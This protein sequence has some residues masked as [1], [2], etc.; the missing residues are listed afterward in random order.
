MLGLQIRAHAAADRSVEH[1]YVSNVHTTSVRNDCYADMRRRWHKRHC[2]PS[3]ECEAGN[4]SARWH[5]TWMSENGRSSGVS[6]LQR[7]TACGQRWWKAQPG[8]GLSGEG[9]SP[10]STIFARRRAG[11]SVGVLA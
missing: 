5:A 4:S 2:A 10:L 1:G 9:T 8:G 3:Y 7:S 11:S 6:T